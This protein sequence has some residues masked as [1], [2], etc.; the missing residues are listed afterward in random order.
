MKKQINNK[1][2][3]IICT[4]IFVEIILITI[5]IININNK[6]KLNG[7]S[8]NYKKGPTIEISKFSDS[9]DIEKEIVVK[10]KSKSKKTF[11]IE[12]K[13][14]NNTLKKQS[15]FTYQIIGKGEKAKSIGVSQ[16]PVAP[17]KI[18][19]NIT[20][21][22]SKKQMYKIKLSYKALNNSEKNSKFSGNIKITSTDKK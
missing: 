5:A 2:A 13:I 15:N 6:E 3:L 9:F 8:V 4:V 19:Q 22:P 17:A 16:V 21:D 10:N 12:W 1:K 18:I 14:V 20:I 7:L 11:N